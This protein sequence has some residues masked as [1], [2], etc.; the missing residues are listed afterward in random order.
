MPNIDLELL[1][2]FGR[3]DESRVDQ[4]ASGPDFLTVTVRKIHRDGQPL[5]REVHSDDDVIEDAPE[6]RDKLC[7]WQSRRDALKHAERSGY[8]LWALVDATWQRA[9]TLGPSTFIQHVVERLNDTNPDSGQWSY[10]DLDVVEAS[11]YHD[12]ELAQIRS[13]FGKSD[14]ILLRIDDQLVLIEWKEEMGWVG[15]AFPVEL[16]LAG[17]IKAAGEK[18]LEL[19]ESLFTHLYV[20]GDEE[21]IEAI[22][23]KLPEYAATPKQTELGIESSEQQVPTSYQGARGLLSDDGVVL[24]T[25]GPESDMDEG[26]FM[27]ADCSRP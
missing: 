5:E 24:L 9:F 6:V 25:G 23:E 13:D 3:I 1:T 17:E 4:Y 16:F 7:L 27:R 14:D 15:C 12:V 10:D 18:R 26:F 19:A 21:L 22:C 11:E 2:P 8:S 20:S